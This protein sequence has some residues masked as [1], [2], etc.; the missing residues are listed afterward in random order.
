MG[1]NKEYKQMYTEIIRFMAHA[2][3]LHLL[4]SLD[5]SEA[6]LNEKSLKN[7]LFI[8][9]AVILYHLVVKKT[10]TKVKNIK[11]NKVQPI[12]IQTK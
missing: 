9:L 12:P 7:I 2:V 6:F 11:K 5:G 10:I 8:L 1:T 3:L 4:A